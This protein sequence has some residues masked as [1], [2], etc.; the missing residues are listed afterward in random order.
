M[1]VFCFIFPA[2]QMK[3][4]CHG[5]SC[6]IQLNKEPLDLNQRFSAGELV[7]HQYNTTH[8][9]IMIS[10]NTVQHTTYEKFLSGM[11]MRFK[12]SIT[13]SL[14]CIQQARIHVQKPLSSFP[15]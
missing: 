5:L 7:Y 2:L 3:A 6:V 15:N 11:D 13:V 9:S 10:A 14:L 12:W 4:W 1:L 8:Y